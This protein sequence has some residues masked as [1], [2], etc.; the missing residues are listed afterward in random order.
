MFIISIPLVYSNLV[1]SVQK[2]PM[3]PKL[4]SK[5]LPVHWGHSSPLDSPREFVLF[6]QSSLT[7]HGFTPK[8]R[9]VAPLSE[10]PPPLEHNS[11]TRYSLSGHRL[12]PLTEDETPDLSRSFL[13]NSSPHLL[14]TGN[15]FTQKTV[16]RTERENR[17]FLIPSQIF[18][19]ITPSHPYFNELVWTIVGDS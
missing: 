3:N 7:F 12:L 8:T 18:P 14:I 9:P 5:F 6:P 1:S 10:K 13:I 16:I 17:P 11:T 4:Y 2:Y 19:L 15:P